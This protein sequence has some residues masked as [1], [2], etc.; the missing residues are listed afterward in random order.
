[1]RLDDTDNIK[2]SLAKFYYLSGKETVL[3]MLWKDFTT[4]EINK[5]SID[6]LCDTIIAS[7]PA[8]EYCLIDD[9][10][11]ITPDQKEIERLKTRCDRRR[12]RNKSR[13]HFIYLEL[14]ETRSKK[15]TK[16]RSDAAD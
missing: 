10:S 9:I 12:C 3:A 8:F 6:S 1:L 5:K 11:S 4:D 15:I 7:V 2:K 13:K 14:R 16:A